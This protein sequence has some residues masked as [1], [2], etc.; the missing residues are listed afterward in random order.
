MSRP[1]TERR[2]SLLFHGWPA[3]RE[4]ANEH[5]ERL[6][7]D[8]RLLKHKRLEAEEYIREDVERLECLLRRE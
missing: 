3:G 6:D 5:A 8:T 1:H 4:E 7:L 2:D